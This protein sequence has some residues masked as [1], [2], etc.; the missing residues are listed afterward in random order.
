M[1]LHQCTKQSVILFSVIPDL[2]V[3]LA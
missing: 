1:V 3:Y 2:S